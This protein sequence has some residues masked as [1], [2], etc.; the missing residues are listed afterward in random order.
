MNQQEILSLRKKLKQAL[1]K[2]D[3]IQAKEIVEQLVVIFESKCISKESEAACLISA[4]LAKYYRKKNHYEKAVYY[5]Q[6]AIHAAKTAQLPF[7]SILIEVYMDYAKLEKEYKQFTNA[8]KLLATLLQQLEKNKWEDE[9]A[10]GLIYR[11][12][13]AI[14][15]EDM[16]FDMTV[17]QLKQ[18][19]TSF[20]KTVSEDHPIIYQTID[21]LAETY[22]R[23]EAYH[24]ALHI[25]EDILRVYQEK[26]DRRMAGIISLR[27]GE[28]YFYIDL[29]KARKVIVEAI[30]LL[31]SLQEPMHLYEAKGNL[32]LAEAEENLAQFP[33]AITY[34]KRGLE[35]LKQVHQAEHFMIVYAYSKIGTLSLKVN[36]LDQAK[37]YLEE[38]I[39]LTKH[40]PRIKMQFLYALGKIYS[41]QQSYSQALEM[42]QSFLS[43]LTIDGKKQSKAYAD[44]L[45]AIAFNYIQQNQLEQALEYYQ[46]AISIYQLVKPI[47]YEELGFSSIRL[48]YCYESKVNKEL[49]KANEWY[50]YGVEKIEKVRNK[51]LLEEA[52]TAVIAFYQRYNFSNQRSF[53]EDKLVKLQLAK[54]TTTK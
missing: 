37:Q 31:Q 47:H 40:H 24:E 33:R 41:N 4:T 39:K 30:D 44:T 6:Q 48:A 51:E 16:T 21:E 1:Y 19:L 22:I 34:Y 14:G 42:Y 32:L 28:I 7:T 15:F 2:N 5:S 8:R 43:Q 45:Q 9:F 54:E 36:Q 52:L 10:Y 25:E 17:N 35:Q 29:K 38:G 3:M 23:L 50:Q 53:Y 49:K 11:L 26:N 46:A 20:R 27:I 18:A 12:L 13:A